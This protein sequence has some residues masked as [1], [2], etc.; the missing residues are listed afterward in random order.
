MREK[1]RIV[2]KK[3]VQCNPKGLLCLEDIIGIIEDLK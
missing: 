3:T 1:F 2:C